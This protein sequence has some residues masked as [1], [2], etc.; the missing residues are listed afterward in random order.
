MSDE[1]KKQS[2]VRPGAIL[3]AMGAETK[4]IT[5]PEFAQCTRSGKPTA[6]ASAPRIEVVRDGDRVARILARC[7]CGET[8][9]IECDY[10]VSGTPAAAGKP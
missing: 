9:T 10:S 7:R 3:R 6:I 8:I 5:P 1:T 4:A 2:G